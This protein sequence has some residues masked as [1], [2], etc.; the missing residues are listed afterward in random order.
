M[1]RDTGVIIPSQDRVWGVGGKQVLPRFKS[2]QGDFRWSHPPESLQPEMVLKWV[3][4]LQYRTLRT[5]A[6]GKAG[7]DFAGKIEIRESFC[8]K[9]VENKPHSPMRNLSRCPRTVG[10]LNLTANY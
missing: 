2:G 3:Y 1:L 4:H 8:S 5:R 6:I 9:L 10:R 7:R